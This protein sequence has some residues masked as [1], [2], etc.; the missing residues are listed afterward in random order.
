MVTDVST[1]NG[2]QGWIPDNLNYGH[3][4]YFFWMLALSSVMNLGVYVL[5]AK[6]YTYTKPVDPI[7]QD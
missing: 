5:V 1:R 7:S 2:G 4:D 3:L 6:C